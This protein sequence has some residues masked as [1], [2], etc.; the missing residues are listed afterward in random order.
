MRLPYHDSFTSSDAR[1]WV[2]YGGDWQLF[3]GTVMNRSDENGAK[4]VTGSPKWKDYEVDADLRMI[5]HEGNVGIIVRVNEEELGVDSYSGYYVGLRSLDSAI[6]MGRA[7]HGWMGNRPAVMAGGVHTGR[8]YHFR[9][10]AVGCSIAVEVTNLRSKV[11]SVSVMEEDNCV[12]R[13]KIGLRSVATGG[14]WRNIFVRPATDADLNA[15]RSRA[16]FIGSPIYPVREDEYTR[17]MEAF[18]H[19]HAAVGDDNLDPVLGYTNV[20]DQTPISIAS[21]KSSLLRD[22]KVTLR[23]VVTLPEPLFMQDSTGGVSVQLD[24]PTTLNAGDEIEIVGKLDDTP[25]SPQFHASEVH[26]LGD[27]T[28]VVPVSITST[29]AAAGGFDGRLVEVRG[30]LHKKSTSGHQIVLW[31]GD[32]EQNFVVTGH[33]ALST[34]GYESWEPESELR[35]RGICSVGPSRLASDGGFTLLLR[36]VNDVEVLS[37]PPWWT[38]R[39]I[40]RYI[41]LLLGLTTLGI[42]IYVRIVHWNMQVV[43]E[44]RERL[45]HDMHDTLAQSFAGVGFHLQGLRNSIRSGTSTL[46]TIVERLDVACQMVAHT[47]R[48]AS[49]EIAALHPDDNNGNDILTTLERSTHSMLEVDCP[50]MKLVRGGI[51]RPYSLTVRDAFFQIGREA[52]A[53]AIRHSKASLITLRLEYGRQRVTLEICDDGVGFNL[54]DFQDSLGI[55]SMRR[56]SLKAGAVLEIVTGI[57]KGACVR[58]NA[59]YRRSLGIAAWLKNSLS[60]SNPSRRK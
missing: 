23:G 27:R 43:M 22:A 35:V 28:L 57:D 47:H 29:Q 1:E 4:L 9:V 37:G 46:S 50:P 12:R 18:V 40:A 32:A 3:D 21:L 34:S 6:V 10:L 15:V 60:P 49:D 26:L 2:P 17:M 31:M 55:R 41:I 39:L 54:P 45:A 8:W 52:I 42:Y 24:Q 30:R 16:S 7:D 48:E 56:R 44:E 20:P 53:N 36:S 11:S 14:A 38:P 13:G 51:V 33:N 58:I 25:S 5:G 19:A 59:P